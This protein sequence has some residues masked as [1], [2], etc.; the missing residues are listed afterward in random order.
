[1]LDMALA[2]VATRAA[3][4]LLLLAFSL[5]TIALVACGGKLPSAD[6]GVAVAL[7]RARGFR[8][9][10]AE[11]VQRKSRNVLAINRGRATAVITRLRCLSRSLKTR[12][13]YF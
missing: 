3:L 12:G 5:T 11:S 2:T 7:S 10:S 8:R 13:R 4:C 1:M 6:R 9:R